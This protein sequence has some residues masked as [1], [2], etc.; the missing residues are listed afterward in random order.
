MGV[1]DLLKQF[2][3]STLIAGT[4]WAAVTALLHLMSWGSVRVIR[5]VHRMR[6]EIG[7]MPQGSVFHC[8]D[9]RV[10][11][12]VYNAATDQEVSLPIARFG[13][14]SLLVWQRGSGISR[15][16]FRRRTTAELSLRSAVLLLVSV[17]VVAVCAWLALTESWLWVYVL[18]SLVAHQIAV[19]RTGQVIYLKYFA[20]SAVTGYLFLHRARLWHPSPTAAASM[21]FAYVI[22]SFGFLAVFVDDERAGV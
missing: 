11:V 8:R 15:A 16:A 13:R 17:P 22:L 19:A 10:H 12:T 6:H 5:L 4:L 7:R 9:G 18:L 2:L 1:M 14:P 3:V 21:L 20:L